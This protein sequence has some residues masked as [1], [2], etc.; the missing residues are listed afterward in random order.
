MSTFHLVHDDLKPLLENLPSFD[1]AEVD[2]AVL[3]AVGD[4]RIEPARTRHP[5]VALSEH[6]AA[7]DRPE[8][9]VRLLVYR[10]LGLSGPL[11]ALLHIHG[12]G[13]IMGKPEH[14]D[15]GNEGLALAAG[16][17]VVSVD[18]RLAPEC[19]A[20]G[21][22]EDCYAALQWLVGH[23]EEFGIDPDRIAVGGESAGGG[24]SAALALLARDR[25][26]PRIAF[27]WL[28]YPMLDDR[29]GSHHVPPHTGE[30]VW[31]PSA[32]RFGWRALLGL[33]PGHPQVSPYAAPARAED[34]AGLPP[35]YIAVG[36]LDLFVDEDIAYARRLMQAGVAVELRVYPGAFHGFDAIGESRYGTRFTAD[37]RAALARALRGG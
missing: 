26:G 15:V 36:A 12:G 10:P 37:N 25:G 1:P 8:G 16:C 30:F 2:L 17:V 4:Q 28:I 14:N 29:T 13:Y 7:P 34:L 33:D 24:L 5:E 9:G 19:P 3:R 11:P 20:P 21:A 27:Q 23:H 22:V 31:T 6:V 18:Y 32:N 35:A